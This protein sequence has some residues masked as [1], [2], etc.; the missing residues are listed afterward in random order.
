MRIQAKKENTG[1]LISSHSLYK[2]KGKEVQ[3]VQRKLQLSC[4]KG[5]LF[6]FLAAFGFDQA[7][8]WPN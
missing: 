1:V 8:F 6:V 4:K 7:V 2:G 3:N 5:L